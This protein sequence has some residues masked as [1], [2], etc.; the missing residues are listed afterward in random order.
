LYDAWDRQDPVDAWEC[1]RE[2]R[3]AKIQ[4]NRNWFVADDCKFQNATP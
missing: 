1:E 4:G 3:V 2:K